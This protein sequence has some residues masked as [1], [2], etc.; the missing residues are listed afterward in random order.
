MSEASR[1]TIVSPS[2]AWGLDASELWEF[3]E[4]VY[5]LVWRS[6]KVRYKQT[7]L[8]ASWA[9]LQP[10]L[11]MVIFTVFFGRLAGMPSDGLP[12]PLFAY[13]GLVLWTYFTSALTHASNSLLEQQQVLTRVYF[14]RL[15]LPLSAVLA[16]AVDLLLSLPILIGMM[17]YYG[18]T[19]TSAALTAPF[20]VLLAGATAM[21]VGLWLSALNVRYRDVRYT[22]P[23]MIQL[24]LLATPVAYPSTL[25]SERWR[26][27]YGL[28]PMASVVE[29]FRWALLGGTPPSTSMLLVSVVTIS[30]V[31]VTGIQ[32]FR[33][34]ERTFADVI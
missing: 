16:A 33:R 17:L 15:L 18:V 29:G 7:V 30:I 21:G 13:S 10:L 20:F 8:G 1:V 6:I 19:P 4:L 11:A 12:Y 5:F 32:F 27:I 31:T 9:V 26:T 25:L 22:I 34:M 24:W 14:P 23:F 28:N 2:R 3:R